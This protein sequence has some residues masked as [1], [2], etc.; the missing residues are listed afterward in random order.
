MEMNLP[1]AEKKPP[2]RIRSALMADESFIYSPEVT[3]L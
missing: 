2:I 3:N 1:F